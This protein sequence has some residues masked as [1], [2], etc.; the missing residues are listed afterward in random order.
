MTAIVLNL[1]GTE[2]NDRFFLLLILKF[3]LDDCY[4][5][6]KGYDLILN[7]DTLS[8]LSDCGLKL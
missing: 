7:Y 3:Y 1:K 2:E 4:L 6:Y 5:L 8:D